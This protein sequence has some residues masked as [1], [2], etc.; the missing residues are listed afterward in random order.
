[1]AYKTLSANVALN[2]H[3]FLVDDIENLQ[4]LPQEPASTAL[5]AATG[6][7]YIC[8]NAGKWVM[9]IDNPIENTSD[10]SSDTDGDGFVI[11]KSDYWVNAPLCYVN[12]DPAKG[13]ILRENM[14]GKVRA[15]S[16]SFE[17]ARNGNYFTCVSATDASLCPCPHA[18][19]VFPRTNTLSFIEKAFLLNVFENDDADEEVFEV[20]ELPTSYDKTTSTGTFVIE[21]MGDLNGSYP[22]G[23]GANGYFYKVPFLRRA[24]A[25]QLH[26][27]FKFR[28]DVS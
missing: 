1:M 12:A 7:T 10:S 24:G 17:D 14:I 22:I 27:A 6:D 13:D 5:V 8:N 3:E 23:Q 21:G 19:A 4:E 2:T 25:E 26:L 16:I 18:F 20:I 11:Q 9:Y 15:L 28:V